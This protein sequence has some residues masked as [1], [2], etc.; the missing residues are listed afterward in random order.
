MKFKFPFFRATVILSAVLIYSFIFGIV[1]ECFDFTG[2]EV[3]AAQGQTSDKGKN[4][5]YLNSKK[6]EETVYEFN[7]WKAPLNEYD[8]FN[9][10][11]LSAILPNT[12]LTPQTSTTQKATT[13]TTTQTTTTTAITTTKPATTTTTMMVPELSSAYAFKQY[14]KALRPANNVGASNP[15][16]AKYAYTDKTFTMKVKISGVIKDVPVYDVLCS[17]V[18]QELNTA[19]I[20]AMKAQAVACYSYYKYKADH[21]DVQPVTLRSDGEISSQVKNAVRAVLGIGVYYGNSIAL[22]PYFSSAGGATYNSENVWWEKIAYLRSVPS[23]YD[24]KNASYYK[25]TSVIS[26]TQLKKYLEGYLGITLPADPRTWFEFLPPEQGG[27]LD[28]NLVGKFYVRTSSGGTKTIT[29]RE[30]R[31]SI[32]GIS[33][34]I[35]R[36]AKFEVS[37]YK[38]NFTFVSYGNGHG[39][40]M[41]QIGADGYARYKGYTY[42]QILRHYFTGVT[43]KQVG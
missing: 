41:S 28:G 34:N 21:G 32:F 38:A 43:I 36:S 18:Q 19:S 24:S 4:Y 12:T 11:D 7:M 26:Q 5:Y 9:E 20:E 33:S 31:E 40:G 39:V 2:S 8:I 30:L 15:P 17:L 42:D 35:L 27:V 14:T 29:G 10:A 23:E 13:Q 25:K 6:Q 16:I 1:R 3:A 37:Y 22:T